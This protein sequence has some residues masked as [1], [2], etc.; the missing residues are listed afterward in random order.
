MTDFLPGSYGGDDRKLS[1]NTRLE[2]KICWYVYD[3]ALGDDYWQIAAGTPFAQLPGDWRC[4]ECD[5]DKSGFM[6]LSDD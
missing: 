6:V 5:G 3:P 1:G 2:C 4:P